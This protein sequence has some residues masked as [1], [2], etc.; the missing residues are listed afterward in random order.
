MYFSRTNYSDS[1][2]LFAAAEGVDNRNIVIPSSQL[3]EVLLGE[4]VLR[5]AGKWKHSQNLGAQHANC[6]LV[7]QPHQ[8]SQAKQLHFGTKVNRMD[9]RFVRH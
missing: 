4:Y 3:P 7:E 8:N 9:L 5:F 1:G 2:R 6:Q